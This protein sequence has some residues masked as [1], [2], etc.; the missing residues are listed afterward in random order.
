MPTDFGRR[1]PV[2]TRMVREIQSSARMSAENPN[3]MNEWGGV[4][5]YT[6]WAK[7]P[8]ADRLVFFATRAGYDTPQAI[9][10]VTDLKTTEV[11]RSIGKLTAQGFIT[12]GEVSPTEM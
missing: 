3:L 12:V 2:D 11:N 6:Y 5:A 10:D 9:A 4:G 7:Q 8:L 1:L